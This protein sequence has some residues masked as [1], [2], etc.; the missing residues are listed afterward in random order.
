MGRADGR[1][2]AGAHVRAACAPSQGC[3]SRRVRS[4]LAVGHLDNQQPY[5]QP[6]RQQQPVDHA[7]VCWITFAVGFRLGARRGL[8]QLAP[9]V[10]GNQIAQALAQG[11][12]RASSGEP[13]QLSAIALLV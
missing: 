8:G 1:G 6:F 13:C 2:S 10:A 4:L 11:P 3:S 5:Q 12:G 9:G 7:L